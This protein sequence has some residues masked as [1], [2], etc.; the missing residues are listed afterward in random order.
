MAPTRF[1]GLSLAALLV[2]RV[3]AQFGTYVDPAVLDACP[4]Y[5][6]T[7]IEAT[8]SSLSA[9][10]TLVGD[11]CNVFGTDIP[12]LALDVTYETGEQHIALSF[13]SEN[14]EL[15]VP[16]RQPYSR[17]DYGPFSRSLR[18]S[19]FGSPSTVSRL[20]CLC[21]VRQNRLQLH[22]R[23]L[24]ILDHPYFYR[25]DPFRYIDSPSHI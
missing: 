14:T 10:L 8:E 20:D 7:D 16:N 9:T 6:A 25:R 23:A 11:G 24:L 13:S 22:S 12:T 5:N 1:C 15:T 17:Q 19:R 21:S 4:G 2:G 3:A 18:S